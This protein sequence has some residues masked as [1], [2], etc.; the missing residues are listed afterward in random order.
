MGKQE[1]VARG[2]RIR[3]GSRFLAA[4]EPHGGRIRALVVVCGRRRNAGGWVGGG[5]IRLLMCALLVFIVA[6]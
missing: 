4:Q 1:V 5:E 2:D 6:P 3:R